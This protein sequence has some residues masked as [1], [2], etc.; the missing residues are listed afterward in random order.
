[1]DVLYADPV[2]GVYRKLVLAEDAHTL[3]GG[4][5]VGDASAYGSLRQLVGAQ[6]GADPASYVLPARG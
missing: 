1:V 6:L 5:L 2:A 3:L 4:I